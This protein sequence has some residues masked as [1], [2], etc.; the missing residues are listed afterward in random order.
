MPIVRKPLTTLNA[1]FYRMIVEG[2]IA[3]SYETTSTLLDRKFATCD[4]IYLLNDGEESP[5]T[6]FFMTG[7]HEL[8]IHGQI[9]PAIY[10]GLSGTIEG[11]KNTAEIRS[12]YFEFLED[13]K[14]LE[15]DA[16]CDH[17]IWTT[18]ATPSVVFAFLNSFSAAYPAADG[19]FPEAIIPVAQ[20][21]QSYLL[22]SRSQTR[23]PFVLSG[24]AFETRYSPTENARIQDIC[25]KHKFTLFS[26]FGVKESNGDRLI[27]IRVSGVVIG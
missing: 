23:N 10:L 20:A 2:I 11:R 26:E 17:V 15:R 7:N 5:I 25:R 9:H 6:S 3:A 12:I 4:T 19:S 18:T 13:L 21:I 1:G 27:L 8:T 24:Y 22:Q 14:T 16:K